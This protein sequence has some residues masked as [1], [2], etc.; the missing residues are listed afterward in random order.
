LEQIKVCDGNPGDAQ[1]SPSH[2][3]QDV[4][5]ATSDR[6]RQLRDAESKAQQLFEEVETRGFIR[7]GISE[8]TLNTDIYKLAYE[9]FG[10]K[11]YWHKRIVRPPLAHSRFTA[12]TF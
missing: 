7:P 5:S 4:T 2:E 10:I 11:K 12:S 3:Q 9:M 6:H 8:E 1:M